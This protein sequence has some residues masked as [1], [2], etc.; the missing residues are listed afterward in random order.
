MFPALQGLDKTDRVIYLYDF[1]RVLYPYVNIA[2]AVIP[3]SMIEVA[4]NTMLMRGAVSPSIEHF[5]LADFIAE[6][7]LQRH[8][9]RSRKDYQS[10]RQTVIYHLTRHFRDQVSIPNH[11]A[12]LHQIV[13]FNLDLSVQDILSCARGAALPLVSLSQDS[14]S[15]SKVSA[16]HEFALA[17]ALLDSQTSPLKI[18]KFKDL[19][20]ERQ[21]DSSVE[22]SVPAKAPEVAAQVLPVAVL[23][24][25]P[26]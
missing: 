22:R 21:R 7:D 12:G 2:V 14:A 25:V 8:I 4:R 3:N 17:F 20:D 11:S 26:F 24:T 10:R 19:I 23:Q 16:G 9:R 5:A 18:A 1:S 6:G 13:R 15:G